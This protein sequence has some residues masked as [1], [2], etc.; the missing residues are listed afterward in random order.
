M[1][2]PTT[3][4]EASASSRSG[5]SR[6]SGVSPS[7]LPTSRRGGQVADGTDVTWLVGRTEEMGVLQEQLAELDA[8]V[9]E[10]W[11]ADV[12]AGVV[13]LVRAAAG[14]ADRAMGALGAEAQRF[15]DEDEARSVAQDLA[16][17]A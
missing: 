9:Q 1:I 8:T 16:G 7:G 5:T 15:E 12:N 4:N 10:T 6:S 3:T 14:D 13:A 11:P 2:D 17:S